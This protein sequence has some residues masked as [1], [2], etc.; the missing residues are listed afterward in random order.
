MV[1]GV[2]ATPAAREEFSSSERGSCVEDYERRG[3][4][5]FAVDA[6]FALYEFF[7]DRRLLLA[8][9]RGLVSLMTEEEVEAER[10]S[11]K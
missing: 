7:G 4:Q 8:E 10:R 3:P 5:Y 1:R 2:W 11:G 9:R 6:G